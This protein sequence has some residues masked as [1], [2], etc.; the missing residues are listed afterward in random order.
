MKVPDRTESGQSFPQYQRVTTEIWVRRLENIFFV[1]EF[2]GIRVPRISQDVRGEQGRAGESSCQGLVL[3][4]VAVKCPLLS[5]FAS[6]FTQIL[7]LTKQQGRAGANKNAAELAAWRKHFDFF[8][9][10]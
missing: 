2:W 5:D 7:E 1:I 9:M 3:G 6:R 4:D 10:S 8:R